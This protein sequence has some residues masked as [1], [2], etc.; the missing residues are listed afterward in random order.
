MVVTPERST[1]KGDNAVAADSLGLR[2]FV[3][4]YRIVL[5]QF[6]LRVKFMRACS[7]TVTPCLLTQPIEHAAQR[8]FHVST[9][10]NGKLT[11]R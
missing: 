5:K 4:T 9:S 11:L 7:Y 10:G 8:V 2:L 1:H 6:V 3:E